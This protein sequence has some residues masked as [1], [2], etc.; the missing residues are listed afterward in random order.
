MSFSYEKED[1]TKVACL[2]RAL[3]DAQTRLNDIVA[4][5]SKSD[6]RASGQEMVQLYLQ[7][8]CEKTL[9][10]EQLDFIGDFEA[11]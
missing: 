10:A 8:D 7:N 9:R 6:S 3:C 4:V 5:S 2:S 11:Y 1:D